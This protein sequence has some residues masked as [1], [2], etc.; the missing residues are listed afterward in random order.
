M[1]KTNFKKDYQQELKKI[2]DKIVANYKPEKIIAFGSTTSSDVN[3]DSDIDLL[4]IKNDKR[5]LIDRIGDV[6]GMFE[7]TL[8]VDIL[9]YTPKEIEKLTRWGDPFIKTIVSEGKVLHG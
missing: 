9:V 4:V 8:P 1:N 7:H 6:S 2:V 5:R 3:E